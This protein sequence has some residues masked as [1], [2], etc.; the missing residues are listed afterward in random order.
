MITKAL[1][2]DLLE[3]RIVDTDYFIVEILVN[4]N[5][6][7]VFIDQNKGISI[8]ECQVIDVS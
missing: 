8:S 2:S 7:S 6:I 3:E 5:K 4:N 1:V